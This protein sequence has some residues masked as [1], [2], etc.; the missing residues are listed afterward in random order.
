MITTLEFWARYIR[1]SSIPSLGLGL[2]FY[3][4]KFY[5]LTFQGGNL[6]MQG[7][8]RE[9]LRVLYLNNFS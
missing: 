2:D 6:F 8:P 1:A 5:A 4:L 9:L 7:M 3:T